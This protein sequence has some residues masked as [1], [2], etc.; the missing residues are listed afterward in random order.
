MNLRQQ[1]TYL[2]SRFL[3]RSFESSFEAFLEFWHQSVFAEIVPTFLGLVDCHDRPTALGRT[4][5]MENLTGRQTVLAR[6]HRLEGCL[7]LGFGAT[8]KMVDDGVGGA[9]FLFS[10]HGRFSVDFPSRV[11][12]LNGG[13][14]VHGLPGVN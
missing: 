5:R 12:R 3:G 4:G 14:L 7:V 9:G 13:L 10:W 2:E 8:G 1:K 11:V 6:M